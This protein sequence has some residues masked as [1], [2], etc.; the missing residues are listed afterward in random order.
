MPASENAFREGYQEISQSLQEATSN[1]LGQSA[2]P[3]AAA[4][5]SGWML[6]KCTIHLRQAQDIMDDLQEQHFWLQHQQLDNIVSKALMSLPEHLRAASTQ[7]PLTIFVNMCL[8]EFTISL[9]QT[10]SLIAQKSHS[11][12]ETAAR[13]RSRARRAA[14]EIIDIMH[15]AA[16]MNIRKVSFESVKDS[17]AYVDRCRHLCPHASTWPPLCTL[18]ISA[19]ATR[20]S[21]PDKHC[22]SFCTS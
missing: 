16:Y 19:L 21:T 20:S 7:N 4:V 12:F 22:C 11:K 6:E 8:H 9:F 2:A 1:G 3:M 18:M 15:S 10:A 14:E 13:L 5:I 17:S